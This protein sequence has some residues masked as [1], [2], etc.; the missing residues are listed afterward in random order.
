MQ[1][2]ACQSTSALARRWLLLPRL[3]TLQRIPMRRPSAK[4]LYVDNIEQN[5]NHGRPLSSP[6]SLPPAWAVQSHSPGLCC[7][8]TDPLPFP[9]ATVRAAFCRYAED[10]EG[11]RGCQPESLGLVCEQDLFH[12]NHRASAPVRVD[13]RRDLRLLAFAGHRRFGVF[14]QTPVNYW[15]WGKANHGRITPATLGATPERSAPDGAT[16]PENMQRRLGMRR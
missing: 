13:S 11:L 10:W 4:A 5:T 8:H 2:T 7:Q 14:L 16:P 9:L 3:S 6:M 1:P 12:R 15:F